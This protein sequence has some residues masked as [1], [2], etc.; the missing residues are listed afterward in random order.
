MNEIKETISEIEVKKDL[1]KSK[2]MATLS[3]YAKGELFYNV[4]VLGDT[5]QF[6]IST[7]EDN[8]DDFY[9]KNIRRYRDTS[10]NSVRLQFHNIDRYLAYKLSPYDETI[11][12]DSDYLIMSDSLNQC[13]NSK[14]DIMINSES[15]EINTARKTLPRYISEFS[16]KMYWATVVYFKKSTEAEQLFS[17]IEHIS[18]NYKFYEEAY[19]LPK[20]TFRNDFAFSIAIHMLNGF[21]E[22]DTFVKELP[23]PFLFK[24]Y[25]ND[26]IYKV[27]GLNDITF[28]VDQ[29]EKGGNYI[30]TRVKDIDLHVMNKYSINRHMEEFSK[31]YD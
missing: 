3:H 22:N 14:H 29:L 11:L 18:K 2:A 4:E 30:L 28:Y 16:I 21:K 10:L 7:V 26:D 19:L 23:I 20:G 13:W 5:Y 6:P 8:E 31:Y 24:T 9:K 25:D 15:I 27:N 1:Y 17:F 12:L